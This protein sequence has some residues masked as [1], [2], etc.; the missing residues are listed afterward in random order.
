MSD[1]YHR[2]AAQGHIDGQ[3]VAPHPGFIQRIA[4]EMQITT[5]R[6]LMRLD[7]DRQWLTVAFRP[8]FDWHVDTKQIPI[9]PGL[10]HF[11][12]PTGRTV[13]IKVLQQAA[14]IRHG[15]AA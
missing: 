13:G 14:E 8:W 7:F 11:V 12:E 10:I 5:G 9:A 2:A 15:G 6:L 4:S 3:T 1:S